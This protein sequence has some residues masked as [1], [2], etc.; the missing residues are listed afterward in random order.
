[1]KATI[2]IIED[3][4][5][6]RENLAEILELHGYE[7]RSEPNGLLGAKSAIDLPPDLILCDVMMPELDGFGVLNLLSENARTEAI[8]FVF[9]TAKTEMEDIR[10]GM[11]L[12]A[13]DYITKPFYKDELLNVIETRLKK[14]A[15]RTTA[16]ISTKTVHLSDPR[17]GHARLEAAFDKL[18]KQKK[19]EACATI[20][21]E[22][23]FPH[24]IFRVTEGRVHL[25][26]SHEHGRN[27][28]IAELGAGEVFG[29][30][31]ILER[32][33]YHYTARAASG[34]STLQALPTNH[35][36]RLLNTDRTVTEALMHLMAGRVVSHGDRLVHQAYDS[37]RRRTALVLCDLHDKYDG[38]G[39]A[40]SRDELAQMVG[41][42]KE[43]VI[44][45][46][47][48]FKREELIEL[49]GKE[50]AVVDVENLRGLLV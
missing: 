21:R 37:V 42:T 48:D 46:L 12:G 43:S 22:G 45:A 35:L 36:L 32:A 23:E 27:Y 14:A 7:V 6:V 24:F 20:I 5:D 17:G 9:I 29:V 3:S 15:T 13:D 26:R 40:L 38:E 33:P 8:P 30:P 49:R 1:M 28:I 31:S 47:S 39:I 16:E 2:L 18:G 25:S 4:E 19:Y 44:R 50:V 10:R 41:T 11:N 34:G